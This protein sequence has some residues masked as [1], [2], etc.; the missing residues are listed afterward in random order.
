MRRLLPQ[1]C[2]IGLSKTLSQIK[3][4][5]LPPAKQHSNSCC[6][7]SL[8]QSRFLIG[9]EEDL[10]VRKNLWEIGPESN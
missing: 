9:L 2:A 7:V 4:I 8:F 5:G 10:K 1:L 3:D 6:T